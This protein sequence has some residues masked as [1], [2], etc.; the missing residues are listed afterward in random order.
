MKMKSIK[1]LLVI[2]L[3]LVTLMTPIIAQANFNGNHSFVKNNQLASLFDGTGI[4]RNR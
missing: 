1:S 4:F 2:T 3:A